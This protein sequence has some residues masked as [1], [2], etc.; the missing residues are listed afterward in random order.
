MGCTSSK[1][2]LSD[3]PSPNR[4]VDTFSHTT[5]TTAA[6]T[7]SG[8]DMSP[9]KTTFPPR[10]PFLEFEPVATIPAASIEWARARGA[11]PGLLRVMATCGTGFVGAGAS[12][13]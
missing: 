6:S 7:L 5:W 8:G 9:S 2:L 1:P 3:D 12:S 11:P 10:G 13:A 4:L